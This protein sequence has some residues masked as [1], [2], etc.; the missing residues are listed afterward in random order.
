M[1]KSQEIRMLILAAGT[2]GDA[3]RLPSG[4]RVGGLWSFRDHA[5]RSART[6]EMFGALK[7]HG[8]TLEACD[9]PVAASV[10]GT[11]HQAMRVVEVEAVN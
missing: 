2:R 4:E 9:V 5:H 3:V 6:G 11:I 1:S 7:S 10:Y 8:L